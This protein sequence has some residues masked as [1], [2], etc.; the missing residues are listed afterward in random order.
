M[1]HLFVQ[2]C[3]SVLEKILRS[4]IE[5]IVYDFALYVCRNPPSK[6]LKTSDD[7]AHS[8][9]LVKYALD[10]EYFIIDAESALKIV[11]LLS[12]MKNETI[13]I[14]TLKE[15]VSLGSIY[16]ITD[17]VTGLECTNRFFTNTCGLNKWFNKMLQNAKNIP[18]QLKVFFNVFRDSSKFTDRLQVVMED[19]QPTLKS[20]VLMSQLNFNYVC[21]LL[22]KYLHDTRLVYCDVNTMRSYDK[23]QFRY[24]SLIKV[25]YMISMT[26][27]YLQQ[28]VKHETTSQKHILPWNII[29][30]PFVEELAWYFQ[31]INHFEPMKYDFSLNGFRE[32]IKIIHH[33]RSIRFPYLTTFVQFMCTYFFSSAQGASYFISNKNNIRTIMFEY[34]M[35]PKGRMMFYLY[36]YGVFSLYDQLGCPERLLSEELLTNLGLDDRRRNTHIYDDVKVDN[37]LHRENAQL[38]FKYMNSQLDRNR[39]LKLYIE[40]PRLF[41]SA[42]VAFETGKNTE[43]LHMIEF[44]NFAEL[45]GKEKPFNILTS[46]WMSSQCRVFYRNYIQRGV[47]YFH[48]PIEC[49]LFH[50]NVR[51]IFYVNNQPVIF[52]PLKHILDVISPHLKRLEYEDLLSQIRQCGE[53]VTDAY[54]KKY[55]KH[56]ARFFVSTNSRFA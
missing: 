17:F 21:P 43:F 47:S 12:F 24:Q 26:E 50:T 4:Y 49:E 42:K 44:Q 52:D 20:R 38:T 25:L 28:L 15:N 11:S 2:D 53:T 51:N 54:G 22:K 29:L 5:S 18:S 16:E 36:K 39:I 6:T 40:C 14:R 23:E 8:L 9:E 45:Q 48:N 31:E 30:E 35:N 3:K 37:V 41:T 46:K 32:K 7:L 27:G 56:M 13:F 55:F 34:S 10:A 19:L 33:I 1:S